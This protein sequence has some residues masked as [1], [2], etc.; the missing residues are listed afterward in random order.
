M[1]QEEIN[2]LDDKLDQIMKKLQKMAEANAQMFEEIR[3]LRDAVAPIFQWYHRGA[4]GLRWNDGIRQRQSGRDGAGAV[5]PDDVRR[6]PI[7]SAS[8]EIAR[9][10]RHGPSASEWVHLGPK[11]QGQ[12]GSDDGRGREAGARVIRAALRERA[13]QRASAVDFAAMEDAANL[14]GVRSWAN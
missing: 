2:K 7:W 14:D 13:P 1:S 10:G 6:G 11:E 3:K 4:R 12:I 9:L 5:V 8:V